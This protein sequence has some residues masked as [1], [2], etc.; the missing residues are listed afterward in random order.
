MA[1]TPGRLTAILALRFGT[2]ACS[3]SSARSSDRSIPHRSRAF[4]GETAGWQRLRSTRNAWAMNRLV[5]D[6]EVFP[7]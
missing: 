7:R 3:G 2:R 4:L 1:D 5:Y 6:L